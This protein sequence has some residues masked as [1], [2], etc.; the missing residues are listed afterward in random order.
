MA[1]PKCAVLHF[2]PP[3]PSLPPHPPQTHAPLPPRPCLS[4][5]SAGSTGTQLAGRALV[6]AAGPGGAQVVRI[7]PSALPKGCQV[8][9]VELYELKR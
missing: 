7:P 1:A 9:H 2:P 8:E 5:A 3:I 6:W 4:S